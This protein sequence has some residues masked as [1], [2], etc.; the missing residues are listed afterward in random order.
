MKIEVMP[1]V[2]YT[3]ELM[4][5]KSLEETDVESAIVLMYK[6]DGTI[7]LSHSHMDLSRLVFMARS[8]QVYVDDVVAERREPLT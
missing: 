7:H 1:N 4:L 3:P 5:H 6:K 8:L 2:D